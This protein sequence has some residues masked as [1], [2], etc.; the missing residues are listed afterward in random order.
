M[1]LNEA[2]GYL[3]AIYRTIFLNVNRINEEIAWVQ[4]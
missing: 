1:K 2:T 3:A 4:A